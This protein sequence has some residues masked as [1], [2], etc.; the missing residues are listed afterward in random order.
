MMWLYVVLY[1]PQH[2]SYALAVR[3][4]QLCSVPLTMTVII[5]TSTVFVLFLQNL[6]SALVVMSVS[7]C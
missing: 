5:I 6:F 3:V 7:Q 4:V 2:S 1:I